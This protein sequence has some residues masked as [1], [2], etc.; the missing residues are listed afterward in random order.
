MVHESA[1]EASINPFFTDEQNC[2][3]RN[4][5]SN[6]NK[7]HCT[8]KLKYFLISSSLCTL[9]IKVLLHG[10]KSNGSFREL[11][12]NAHIALCNFGHGVKKL[13]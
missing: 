13:S 8:L 10:V 7:V 2:S 3:E 6:T 11:I 4:G 12:F 9:N 5:R 1:R